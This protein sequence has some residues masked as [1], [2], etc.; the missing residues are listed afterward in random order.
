MSTSAI[1][2]TWPHIRDS[3]PPAQ[4]AL[5]KS[6]D[7]IQS[8]IAALL[9]TVEGQSGELA[10][11]DAELAAYTDAAND[12]AKRMA[13]AGT[14]KVANPCQPTVDAF[15][16]YRAEIIRRMEQAQADIVA[17]AVQRD[18]MIRR[19]SRHVVGGEQ[20]APAVM[21]KPVAKPV[22]VIGVDAP[23][24]GTT[25]ANGKRARPTI[26]STDAAKVLEVAGRHGL[27]RNMV[28]ALGKWMAKHPGHA[29]AV[30]QRIAA[31]QLDSEISAELG[32]AAPN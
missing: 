12:F 29:D 6:V 3:L 23:T 26:A 30:A 5:T 25:S 31:R 4:S 17:L 32:L 8:R 14:P 13:A 1:A 22:V 11:V 18:D 19:A 20:I 28:A 7:E 10:R 15:T 16:K 27:P 9:V 24:S 2:G 21:A